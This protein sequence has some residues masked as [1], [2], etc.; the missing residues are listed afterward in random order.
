MKNKILIINIILLLGAILFS[1][2]GV[3]HLL[4]EYIYPLDDTYIHLSIAK[5]FAL[6]GV[7]GITKYKYSST[8]SSPFFT[9]L[10][11]IMIKIFGNNQYI[12]IFINALGSIGIIYYIHKFF[13]QSDTKVYAASV[14]LVIWLMP[15]YLMILMGM[16]HILHTLFMI[17]FFM[18]LDKYSNSSKGFITL[19][20]YAIIATGLRY[21]SLFFIF[22][23][24]VYLFFIRRKFAESII[25]GLVS[26]SPVIIYGFVSIYQGAYFLP[27]S[28]I[29]KGNTSNGINSFLIRILSNGYRAISILPLVVFLIIFI[30][31]KWRE[32][33]QN[34]QSI[35]D[36]FDKYRIQVII[37]LGFGIHLCFANFGWLVRYEAYLLVLLVLAIKPMLELLFSTEYKILKF[38]F[39]LLLIVPA[40]IRLVDTLK[41][42]KIASKNIFD[43]HI[44]MAK[45]L[46][47]YYNGSKIVANDIGAITYFTNIHL[48][49]IYGLGSEE[50]VEIRKKDQGKF[51]NQN[52]ELTQFVKDYS[53]KEK[54]DIAIVYDEWITMPDS[55]IKVGEWTIKNGYIVGGNTVSFYAIGKDKKQKLIDD[56]KK[57]EKHLPKDVI[58]TYK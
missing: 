2:M 55:F 36:F 6:D 41:F 32:N 57:Y 24:C 15:M 30:L 35:I 50:I 40:K 44:Q 27:N 34:H 43:Q 8:T 31:K 9:L 1:S 54:Y 42:Q 10:L 19:C 48:L 22:F 37:F 16:E 56:L 52:K 23:A 33:R 45:F 25:L 38:V 39:I 11:S 21:E 7:W 26:I 4:G 47:N 20:L 53:D 51:D 3:I 28:L 58:Y 29:L 49:D 18:Q 12:P 17:M 13:S 14:I 46:Q 5:N